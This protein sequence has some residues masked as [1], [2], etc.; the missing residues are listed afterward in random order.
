MGC[1]CSVFRQSIQI[2]FTISGS[3]HEQDTEERAAFLPMVSQALEDH[4]Q[5]QDSYQPL[6]Y[7]Y[8]HD[9]GH[10]TA[11]ESS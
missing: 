8:S 1:R 7:R 6:P 10:F 11:S 5:A 2:G 4:Q 9:S 3:R